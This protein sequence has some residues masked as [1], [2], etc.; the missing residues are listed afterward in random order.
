MRLLKQI[1]SKQ[2]RHMPVGSVIFFVC[3]YLYVWLFIEPRLIY[4]TFGSSTAYPYFGT[5]WAFLK[6]SLTY[7]GGLVEYIVGFLSQLYYFSWLGALVITV[8]AW[9]M[10]VAGRI[11]V[12]L[13]AG[14]LKDAKTGLVPKIICYIPPV[15][16]LM[17]HNY[18]E[19]SL[20]AFLSLLIT[21]WFLIAYE[22]MAL[23]NNVV[24]IAV[25]LV[26]F[27][28]LYYFVGATSFVFVFLATI[29]EIFAEG[30]KGQKIVFPVIALG[31]YFAAK[32]IWG[33]ET[34]IISPQV[35][36]NQLT[37]YPLVKNLVISAYFFFPMV[38]SAMGLWQAIRNAF[39]AKNKRQHTKDKHKSLIKK[40]PE[41]L[42][43]HKK[44]A[45]AM[46][47]ALPVV[48]LAIGIFV[49]F[50][51]TRKKLLQ[52]ECFAQQKMWPQILQTA[53]RIQPES[54]SLCCI[55][56]VNRALYHT[57]R[58]SNEMFYYPQKR[59][60]LL[61]SGLEIKGPTIWIFIKR[62]QIYLE[63][64]HAGKAERDAFEY[65]ATAGDNPL[66]LEQLATIKLV[67]GQIEAAKVFLKALSKDLIFGSRGRQM[68]QRLE[69]DPELTNDDTIQYLRSVASDTDNVEFGFH[70]WDF[71]HSLLDKNKNNKMA[72]EYM[73]AF[74]LLSGMVEQVAA[75]FERLSDFDYEKVPQYYEEAIVIAAHR[76]KNLPGLNGWQPKPE[77]AYRAEKSSRIYKLYGGRHNERYI[78]EI[79]G[80]DFK[81]SYFLYCLFELPKATK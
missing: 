36:A 2:N 39:A 13:S 56:N 58:L 20:I 72:F 67:K 50:D 14:S 30:R 17:T 19:T 27:C 35:S 76:K 51:N 54:Y 60:A 40:T 41:R 43:M 15:M 79:L 80:N 48:I 22:K 47:T 37:G 73:M 49:S 44:V 38:L 59:S 8:I 11:L 1:I 34:K 10:Y 21:L 25:F 53:R 9:L 3:F 23:H 24:R 12:S 52:V 45:W 5:G 26:E 78:R 57:G 28:A 61:F 31:V 42:L 32:Y 77:T 71:F 69:Q 68:L 66:I 7:S 16:L 63:L 18:Y 75:N 74:Y 33:L 81:G 55:H 64:G 65:L 62:S 6:N 70:A 46:E 29:Y 4:Y